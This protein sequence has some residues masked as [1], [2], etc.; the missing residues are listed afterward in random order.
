MTTNWG[1]YPV[2][3]AEEFFW[4]TVKTSAE[5]SLHD[6]LIA[7]AWDG[8]WRSS[9]TI[10]CINASTSINHCADLAKRNHP[11]VSW[12]SNARKI[13]NIIFLK[14]LFSCESG[15]KFITVGGAIPQLHG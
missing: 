5:I 6:S 3:E 2:I 12:R 8:L 11:P 1:N 14:V 9:L 10:N 15:T 7:L 4:T 13:L